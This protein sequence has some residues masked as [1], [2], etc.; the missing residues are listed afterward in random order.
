M[1]LQH[2]VLELSSDFLPLC[3]IRK[4]ETAEVAT[5]G[6]LNPMILLVLLLLL[7]LPFAGNRQYPVFNGNFDVFPLDL[8]QFRLDEVLFVVLADVDGW[9]PLSHGHSLFAITTTQR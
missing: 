7:H 6:S 8:R 3:V 2:A 9:H 1:H 5:I 4:R